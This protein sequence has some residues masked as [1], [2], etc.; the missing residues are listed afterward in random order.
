MGWRFLEGLEESVSGRTRDL[1]SFVD[2]I[3]LC[4]EL[5]WRILDSFTQIADIV[6]PAIAGRVDLND[7]RGRACI[8]SFA[9]RARVARAKLGSWVKAIDRFG[10]NAGGCGFTSAPWTT[11]EVGVGDPVQSDRIAQR[12]DDVG[13]THEFRAVETSWP[14]LAIKRLGVSR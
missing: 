9:V 13:L 10:Q 12:L 5:A 6:D 2:D 4:L 14:I 8:N 7:I 1:V 3:E 11:K